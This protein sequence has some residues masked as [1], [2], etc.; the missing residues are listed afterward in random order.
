MKKLL[1]LVS[2]VFFS[3]NL[4]AADGSSGCGP[5]WYLFKKNSLV[6]SSLRATTNG[7]LFP[8]TT[9]GM[10]MGTSN[11]SQHAIVKNEQESLK[12]ATENYYEIASD[13]AKGNGDFL[14]SFASTIGCK[15]D[16][17]SV[18]NKEMKRNFNK[19]YNGK[20]VDP[21]RMLKETY[22][23]IF[24]NEDLARSCTANLS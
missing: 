1:L 23:L 4:L 18:F 21:E 11:C 12:F 17:I 6:S 2:L 7:I 5:G 9:I 15:V 10:T 22:I 24:S 14:V 13:A 16:N 19:I 20:K 3:S 8:S